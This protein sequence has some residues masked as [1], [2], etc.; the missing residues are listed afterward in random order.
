[1]STRSATPGCPSPSSRC[2]SRSCSRWRWIFSA[3][4]KV[5]SAIGVEPSGDPFNS[6]RLN[7]ENHPFNPMVNAGAI[8]CTG[9]IYDS[10][11]PEAFEQ[12]R[13]GAQPLCRTR[14]RRRRGGLRVRKPDRRPQPRHRL[15]PQDQ[16]GDLGQCRRRARRLFP[17]MRGAGHRARHR[18]DGGDARQSRRQSGHRRTGADAVCDLAHALGDDVVG[19][20]RLCRRVDLPDRHPRQERRRRRHSGRAPR[21]PRARQLFAKARQARQ[22]RARHQGLRSPVLALRPA[23]AQPQRRRPQR[24]DRRLRHR[25][26]PVTPRPPSA[27]ARHP[28]RA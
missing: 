7:A 15:S 5:E 4:R 9:L 14:P 25:Q 17:A 12:I 18:G 3:R 26:E 10:K 1:M 27:G 8:A 19:H 28:R 21:P 20:V 22:Q 2:Q 16:C 11:G 13:L 23:H 24:R 6:I